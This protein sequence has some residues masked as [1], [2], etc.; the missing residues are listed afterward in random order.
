MRLINSLDSQLRS[1]LKEYQSGIKADMSVPENVKEIV[2]K[3]DNYILK[4]YRAQKQLA[5]SLH[6]AKKLTYFDRKKN[7]VRIN[8]QKLRSILSSEGTYN[9]PELIR[10][11]L[12]YRKGNRGEFRPSLFSSRIGKTA[13]KTLRIPKDV[14][15]VIQNRLAEYARRATPLIPREDEK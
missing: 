13:I 1:E 15:Q 9:E 12:V 3:V 11:A 7:K 8:D 4:N 2:D 6:E 5:E 10:S 14:V